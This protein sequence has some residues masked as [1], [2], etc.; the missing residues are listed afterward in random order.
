MAASP[1]GTANTR[2]FGIA[3]RLAG[4]I[5][6]LACAA[7]VTALAGLHATQVYGERVATLRTAAER[8]V[9]GERINGLIN[10]VVMDSRGV[11]MAVDAKQVERFGRPLLANL[12]NFE[13]DMAAWQALL[14]PGRRE[15][16]A[17]TMQQARAF[18]QLRTELVEAG[19]RHGAAAANAIGNN[20]ANRANRQA[21]N[22]SVVALA[23]ANAAEVAALAAGL[24]RFRETMR[25]VLAGV[26]AGGILLAVVLALRLAVGGI[27]RPLARM[28]EAMRALASGQLDFA[29]PVAARRDEIGRMAAALEVF[30]AQAVENRDHDR[31]RAEAEAAAAEEKRR[32]LVA[33]AGRIEA[34]AGGAVADIA[35]RTQAVAETA[36]RMTGLAARTGAAAGQAEQA[37]GTALATARE[38]AGSA[39][40][41][42]LSIRDIS[43]QVMR[44]TD[45]VGAAVAAGARTRS[46]I[47]ALNGQ[48]AEIGA[49]A[50]MIGSIAART[51][52]LALNATIEAAR[53]GDAGKGF[54]VVASEVKQL[55][56]QTARS[57]EE[58]SRHIAG[59]RQGTEQAVA[60]VAAIDA[61]IGEIDA[62]AAAIAAAVA[63]QG[64]ATAAIA[65]NVAD[66]AA[67][68]DQTSRRNADV[69]AEAA[70]ADR[71]ARAVLDNSQGLDAAVRDLRAAIVQIVRSSTAEVDRRLFE[72]EAA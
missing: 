7:A 19:R 30:R 41:L 23:A 4:V 45:A 55:A 61:T 49:V 39:D 48:V 9:L 15:E 57:T 8:A 36:E 40:E 25:M 18:V 52:L 13:R 44:S 31:R 33:M 51:N 3:A 53:A 68:M 17:S 54:A 60:A 28:T 46:A 34:E 5:A 22:D 50:E 47:G 37:A 65:R 10:A 21:L 6:L 58:I 72:R 26:S 27:A 56:S 70:E 43:R 66:A 38:V 29:P 1:P 62:I 20:E 14:P 59:V 71:Y 32:A 69:A 63:Q 64:T 42:T 12:A 67:A 11:Y 35:A 16:L 2:G 24:D